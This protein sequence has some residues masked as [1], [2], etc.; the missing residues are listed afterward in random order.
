M[1]HEG[2]AATVPCVVVDFQFDGLEQFIQE[3]LRMAGGL[4]LENEVG[5]F[6]QF[7]QKLIQLKCFQIY[8]VI[9]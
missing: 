4:S 6:R 5:I 7:R 8:Y 1:I 3:K 2:L 9:L